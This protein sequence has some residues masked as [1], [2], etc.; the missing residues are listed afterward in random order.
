MTSFLPDHFNPTQQGVAPL[1]PL[2]AVNNALI[3]SLLGCRPRGVTEQAKVN[4]RQYADMA[5]FEK[6]RVTEILTLL[7][8]HDAAIVSAI[9]ESA[10][11]KT[12]KTELSWG[13]QIGLTKQAAH[14]LLLELSRLFEIDLCCSKYQLQ[15]R[16][17]AAV[18]YQ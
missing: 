16:S 12:C 1:T 2:E 3:F 7:S 13:Q 11:I 6:L 18:Y 10:I 15:S 14:D 9:A 17:R 4:A 5:A 8:Q